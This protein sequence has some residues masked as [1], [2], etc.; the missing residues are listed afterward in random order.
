M[1]SSSGPTGFT[2]PAIVVASPRLIDAV[3][4]SL[5]IASL[6]LGL[7]VTLTMLSGKLGAGVLIPA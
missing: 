1:P 7:M 4:A 5:A 3:A 2:S 6:S